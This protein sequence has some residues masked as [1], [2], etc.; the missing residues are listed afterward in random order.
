MAA[1]TNGASTTNNMI[2]LQWSAQTSPANGDSSVLS[3]N[4]YWNQGTN[5]WVELFGETT[6]YTSTSFIATSGIVGGTTY[7][8]K[9]R[10]K[11]QWGWS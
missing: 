5:S 4:V 11:N 7:Q 3:Y 10:S 1:V 9:I 6:P 8:F 2:E